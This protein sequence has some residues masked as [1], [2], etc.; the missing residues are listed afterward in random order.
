MAKKTKKKLKIQISISTFFILLFIGLIGFL[1]Y[2]FFL[3]KDDSNIDDENNNNI[4][5][6]AEYV[7]PPIGAR[8]NIN[9]SD[10]NLVVC[11]SHFDSPGASSSEKNDPNITNQGEQ[12][13][14]EAYNI[15]KVL[16]EFKI[17]FK[18]ENIFFMG[19]TNIKIN[20]QAKAFDVKGLKDSGY[21]FLFEDNPNYATSLSTTINKFS[22]P[23]DKIIYSLKDFSIDNSYTDIES[24]LKKDI[25]NGFIINTYYTLSE[26]K[27]QNNEIVKGANWVKTEKELFQDQNDSNK[28]NEIKLYQRYVQYGISDHLPVGLNI[29]N[30]I[31]SLR[32]GLWNVLNFSFLSTPINGNISDSSTPISDA[33]A[34]AHARNLADIISKADFDLIGLIE[35]NKNTSLNNFKNFLNYLNSISSNKKY[36]GILTKNSVSKI[37]SDGQIEQ[38]AFIYDKN[39]LTYDNSYTSY[40]YGD[41]NKNDA[42]LGIIDF[43]NSLFF[44]FMTTNELIYNRHLSY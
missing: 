4:T 16:D 38:V 3:K 11:Y 41:N 14:K 19:D 37:G 12:E 22:N 35:I 18:T 31:G 2:F 15:G 24:V 25:T 42:I 6:S 5:T 34:N 10:D 8:F 32:I 29:K 9:N 23:Y 27:N 28:Y 39:L 7:R 26:F 36:A 20:N 33:K 17:Y 43:K 1:I 13:V 30:E 44:V 40:F 21:N